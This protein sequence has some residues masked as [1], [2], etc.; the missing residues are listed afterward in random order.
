MRE[1]N[2]LSDYAWRALGL[3]GVFSAGS[4][5][6]LLR[7]MQRERTCSMQIVF[8]F[9]HVFMCNLVTGNRIS[10]EPYHKVFRRL[11]CFTYA[12]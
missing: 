6:P 7:L 4:C 3:S 2:L 12:I 11:V 9:T 5:R 8:S 10:L 1:V